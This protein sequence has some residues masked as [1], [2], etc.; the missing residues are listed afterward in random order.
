MAEI[1][2][3]QLAAFRE[4]CISNEGWTQCWKDDVQVEYSKETSTSTVP[5]LKV[6]SHAF[7]DVDPEKIF[8]TLLDGE[9]R[10]QWD[11]YL[12][13]WDIVD[14]LNDDQDVVHMLFKMPMITNRDFVFMNSRKKENGEI[15]F[16]MKS[17]D[18]TKCPVVNDYVRGTMDMSGY[19]IRKENDKTVVYCVANSDIGGYVPKWIVNS[20]AKST[21]PNMLKGLRKHCV[22]YEDWKK[23]QNNK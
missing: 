9:Y 13:K 21:V 7:N 22:L 20:M 23:K 10:K 1:T 3:D 4:F 11:P 2:P 17:C 19:L 14:S 5:T 12:I 18:H 16:F 15:I 6:I 8:N